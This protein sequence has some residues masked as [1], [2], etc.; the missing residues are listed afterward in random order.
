MRLEGTRTGAATLRRVPLDEL[1]YLDE[2][3]VEI[4][5]PPEAVWDAARATFR[6]NLSGPLPS[7][8]GRLLGCDPGPGAELVGFR[9]VEAD[10]PR[11]L[12]IAGR[13]RFSRYGIVLRV[14]PAPGGA[15]CRLES[16][17]V[18]PGLHGKAYRLA[19]VGSGAHVVA[20]RRLLR[21]VRRAAER[22]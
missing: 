15:R 14:D 8:A 16:R 4:A 11:L 6:G 20:V 13:H 10:R 12:V 18:F 2:H 19:V 21:Q 1:P 7:L 3:A 9:E 5:A 17:A 22:P